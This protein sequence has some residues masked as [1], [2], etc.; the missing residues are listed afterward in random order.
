MHTIRLLYH[1]APT[2]TFTR[3]QRGKLKTLLDADSE[4]AD[5]FLDAICSDICIYNGKRITIAKGGK[6]TR[7]QLRKKIEL[8]LKD[9]QNLRTRIE[10][11]EYTFERNLLNNLIYFGE[12]ND[13]HGHLTSLLESLAFIEERLQLALTQDP[14][15]LEDKIASITVGPLLKNLMPVLNL[16]YRHKAVRQINP[17]RRVPRKEEEIELIRDIGDKYKQF[18]SKYPSA[19]RNGNFSRF[20]SALFS[21]L[22]ITD[23][24]APSVYRLVQKALE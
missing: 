22:E 12:P 6:P 4:N 23:A 21:Q 1:I 16:H 20:I 7:K 8:V 5:K 18:L 13:D 2:F 15:E 10:T 11:L 14:R 19:S 3:E 24:D 9:V 17:T